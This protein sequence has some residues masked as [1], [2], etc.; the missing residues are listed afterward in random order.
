MTRNNPSIASSRN[1][2]TSGSSLILQ[3]LAVLVAALLWMQGSAARADDLA[4]GQA[5]PDFTLPDQAGVQHKLSDYAGKWVVLYFYPR[6]FTSGCTTEACSFRDDVYQIRDLGAVILG[7]SVDS[8]DSHA[9]FAR[10]YKLPFTL[11]SDTDGKVVREYGSLK[12]TKDEVIYA[13][14]DTFIVAPDGKIALILRNVEPK[15]HS[16]EVIASLKQ[17]GAG[18]KAN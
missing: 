12:T 4:V 14:R 17:L 6:D 10:K 3:A 8:S 1:L 18:Q 2:L 15:D 5:A 7:V 9:K 16:A 13:S 11:L